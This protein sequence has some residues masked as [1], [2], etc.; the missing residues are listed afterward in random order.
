MEPNPFGIENKAIYTALESMLRGPVKSRIR[1]LNL[2]EPMVKEC[3]DQQGLQL[4]I[5]AAKS[6]INPKYANFRQN[7]Y[8]TN[9]ATRIIVDLILQEQITGRDFINA[10]ISYE[11]GQPQKPFTANDRVWAQRNTISALSIYPGHAATAP[12]SIL[13]MKSGG[14]ALAE[15]M[16]EIA[17]SVLH[18]DK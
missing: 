16:I 18:S 5:S 8:L 12:S 17:D 1:A 7:E 10:A 3:P 2:L 4:L 9:R 6:V 13:G 14:P 15:A 11:F